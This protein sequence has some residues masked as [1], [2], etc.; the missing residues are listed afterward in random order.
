MITT[1]S[2]IWL[3]TPAGLFQYNAE[4]ETYQRYNFPEINVF[5]PFEIVAD[6]DQLWAISDSVA[7]YI[8]LQIS[9]NYT[10]SRMDGLPPGRLT[11]M[12]SQGD[13]VWV[14]SDSGAAR[15]DLL[16]EQWEYLPLTN[17]DWP[18]GTNHVRRINLV[19]HYLFMATA[20]GILRFDTRTETFVL[21]DRSDGLLAG[22]YQ[23]MLRI[24]DN[25]WCF[26]DDG[27][28]I[29]SIGQQSWSYIG[30]DE[31]FR[32]NEWIDVQSISGDLY[33]LHADGID[34]CEPSSRRIFPFLR[35]DQLAECETYDLLGTTNEIWFATDGGL[36]RYRAENPQTGTTESWIGYDQAY[37]GTAAEY[38]GIFSSGNH[39]FALWDDGLD[40]FEIENESFR[41]P[42][43]FPEQAEIQ[44]TGN[45]VHRLR[46]DDDGLTFSNLSGS[47]LGLQGQYSYRL[48]TDADRTTERYWGRLQPYYRHRSGRTVNSLYDNTD[49]DRILYGATYR[50]NDADFLR[51][52]DAGNR[53]QFVQTHDHLFGRATLRG[54]TA[55]FEAGG[56]SQLKK[57]SL[58]R[59]NLTAGE[60]LTRS[61]KDFFSG[62]DGPEYSLSHDDVLIGSAEVILNGEVLSTEEYTLY[63]SLGKLIL[64]F[65]GWE[66]LNE[67]DIIEVEYQYRLEEDEIGETLTA[68]EVIISGSDSFQITASAF[69]KGENN[70]NIPAPSPIDQSSF[71]GA[72][73]TAEATGKLWGA[74]GKITTGAGIGGGELNEDAARAGFI[75][76]HVKRDAWTLDANWLAI[77][78]DLPTLEDRSTEFGSLK[79]EYAL[80]FKYEPSGKLWLEGSTGERKGQYGSEKN[81]HW[82][83][84]ISPVQGTSLHCTA[85]Y[86]DAS[87]DSLLR[88]RQIATVGFETTFTPGMLDFLKLRSSRLEV[89]A[90]T[91]QVKLDSLQ[92]ADSSLT[93]LLTQSV[94]TRWSIIPGPSISLF[95]EIRW[96]AGKRAYGNG[97]FFPDNEELTPRVTLYSQNLIPGMTTYFYGD[98]NY[99]QINYD[100]ENGV[101]D[102]ELTR[103]GIAQIDLA[104]GVYIST[105]NPISFRLNL[106]RD[107][108]DSL[109]AVD[110]EEGLFDLGMDWTAF[111][112]NQGSYRF[113]SDAIQVTWAMHSKWL[114]YQTV[115]SVRNTGQAEEQ[116]FSTRLE[117]KPNSYDQIYWKYRLSR[118]LAGSGAEYEYEPGIEW[119]RRW[120]KHTFTRGQL[121]VTIVDEPNYS[122]FDLRPGGYIERRIRLPGGLGD[123][124]VRIDI[125]GMYSRQSLPASEE[126]IS[127]DGYFRI[128]WNI[129]QKLTF[130]I[131]F[132]E[133]YTYSITDASEDLN[134]SLEFLLNAHF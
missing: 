49:P 130:R 20:G 8:N 34:V 9:G 98:M 63:T 45:N 31:G 50:G 68:G 88:E 93:K 13:Y 44:S 48:Q 118:K 27:I 91:S 76:G 2:T 19:D 33:F 30:E 86:F 87:T 14:G 127:I 26:G 77:T 64:N 105:L 115:S 133:D 123:N 41:R 23:D 6:E 80:G 25:L 61:A 83:G 65:T 75:E 113:D 132:D 106:A 1:E 89:I 42:L 97:S 18:A 32:N 111:P 54:G 95:P 120:S 102:L 108:R 107:A 96:S 85:D 81:Y 52:I 101:R 40:V 46:W 7:A 92:Y 59:G 117:W 55:V 10:F 129:Q 38:K 39:I 72:Q 53:V 82:G 90:R 15:F 29:L 3:A 110:N 69:K 134:W 5:S 24:G 125:S 74:E 71:S 35:E 17:E 60:R 94:L 22:S 124:T 57:R 58:F 109:L 79:G 103:Q 121:F 62:A 36:V 43:I 28:D 4:G 116:Y 122:R 11:C 37:G 128:G 104:P 21:Y 66:L 16:I 112:S 100:D 12:A 70:A 67:G 126:L 114:L 56:R 119:Y 51:R 84:S 78:D 99:S 131:R 73:L 47:T